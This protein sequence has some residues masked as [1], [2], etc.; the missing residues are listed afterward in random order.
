[1]SK[2]SAT[3][4]ILIAS[5]S[6]CSMSECNITLGLYC[7]HVTLLLVWEIIYS[8]QTIS[9]ALGKQASNFF[10]TYLPDKPPSLL[11]DGIETNATGAQWRHSDLITLIIQDSHA[12]AQYQYIIQALYLPYVQGLFTMTNNGYFT[13]CTCSSIICYDITYA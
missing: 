4:G 2:K 8:A 1:M 6:T 11:Q 5:K 7:I 10:L 9:L 3:L 12:C 13:T